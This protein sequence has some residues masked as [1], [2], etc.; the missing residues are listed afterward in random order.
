MNKPSEEWP[1]I[2]S[3][4]GS[5]AWLQ[6]SERVA[7]TG[8]FLCGFIR[9][10]TALFGINGNDKLL[11]TWPLHSC[12]LISCSPFA[13]RSVWANTLCYRPFQTPCMTVLTQ[14]LPLFPCQSL[15]SYALILRHF[16]HVFTRFLPV[17]GSPKRATGALSNYR[18][19]KIK[20]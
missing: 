2:R 1:I 9:T 19:L 16:R 10:L 7:Q 11:Q 17:C 13:T 18:C 12:R 4:N 14:P 3:L 20:K 6:Q 8:S 5:K 15:L